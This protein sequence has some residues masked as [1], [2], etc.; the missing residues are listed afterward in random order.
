MIRMIAATGLP[1]TEAGKFPEITPTRKLTEDIL[2]SLGVKKAGR[3]TP[4]GEYA[5]THI[6]S[7]RLGE[8]I[9]RHLP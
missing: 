3:T 2:Q 8:L 9:I 7:P 5:E 6:Q 4:V 1:Y